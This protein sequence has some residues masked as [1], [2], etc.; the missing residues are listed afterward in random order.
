MLKVNADRRGERVTRMTAEATAT[1][2]LQM[3]M[4]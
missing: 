1:P 4:A 3:R 2:L